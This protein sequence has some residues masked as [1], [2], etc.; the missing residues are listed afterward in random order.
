MYKF[1]LII[2][3]LSRDIQLYR[4]LE[5]INNTKGFSYNDIEIIVVDQN[6]VGF[7]VNL[8][9]YCSNFSL[10]H[11][12][13][14]TKGIS[15]NRNIGISIAAGEIL[16]F[17]DDDC[18]YSPHTLCNALNILLNTNYD[19]LGGRILAS[20]SGKG[21][22]R[23]WPF[24]DLNFNL[25]NFYYITTSITIFVK[26][27]SIIEFDI[28]LGLPSKFGSCEDIDF[29]YRM[30]CLKNRG[31]YSPSVIIYHPE[32]DNRIVSKEKVFSYAAGLGFF[33]SKNFNFRIVVLVFLLL[34][35]KFIQYIKFLIFQNYYKG[36]FKDFFS[37]F[38]FGLFRNLE[39]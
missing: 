20:N 30:L 24:F 15:Y 35:N 22:F 19:F 13:S 38:F 5:S 32:P 12:H 33:I 39:D 31:L 11:I 6:P 28:N 29:I 17:P 8:E 16:A 23:K 34:I 4:L 25:F 27:R 36:Y 1:S 3:T 37:G 2:V 18:F 7:L 10:K 9:Y 21:I 26:R 14:Q